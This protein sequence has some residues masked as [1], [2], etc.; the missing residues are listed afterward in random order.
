MLLITLVSN[1]TGN[2]G[3]Q[4]RGWVINIPRLSLLH[5]KEGRE[6]HGA[7]GQRERQ[8]AP[9]ARNC[10]ARFMRDL[11]NIAAERFNDRGCFID[12]VGRERGDTSEML[13]IVTD[14]PPKR[15]PRQFC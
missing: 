3:S 9:N 1:E 5:Q 11:D 13:D 15:F 8:G 10:A 12:D 14:G 6:A 4:S 2:E 7:N